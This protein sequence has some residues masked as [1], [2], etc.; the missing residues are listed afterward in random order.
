MV[1]DICRRGNG[2]EPDYKCVKVTDCA[3]GIRNEENLDLCSLTEEH[4]IVCCPIATKNV[5]SLSLASTPPVK[6]VQ[7]TSISVESTQLNLKFKF[8]CKNC[9]KR[10]SYCRIVIECRQ[11]SQLKFP[12]GDYDHDT[13]VD[14]ITADPQ[15]FPHMVN[16]KL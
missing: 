2:I 6:K 8:K 9:L 1:G 13:T 15:E 14:Q 3:D 11:Y 4:P 16:I 12:K 5:T 10:L 7:N